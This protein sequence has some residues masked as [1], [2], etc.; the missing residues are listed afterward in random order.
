MWRSGSVRITAAA[1]SPHRPGRWGSPD[2][3]LAGAPACAALR[4]VNDPVAP[5]PDAA[6][7][8]GPDGAAIAEFAATPLRSTPTA[9]ATP[10]SAQPRAMAWRR[11]GRGTAVGCPAL[12]SMTDGAG[13]VPVALVVRSSGFWFCSVR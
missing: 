9:A 11:L 7:V 3:Y 8:G 13:G 6:G 2:A 12:V 10:T 4:S 1:I 5:A